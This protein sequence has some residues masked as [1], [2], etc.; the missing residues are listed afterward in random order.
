MVELL[1]TELAWLFF[2][3][4]VSL[5]YVFIY[6]TQNVMEDLLWARPCAMRTLS[7]IQ[8]IYLTTSMSEILC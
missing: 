2:S 4:L 1:F 6:F 7:I 5:A 8:Q 3:L